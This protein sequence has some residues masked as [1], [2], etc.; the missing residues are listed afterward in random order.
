MIRPPPRSTLFPYTTLFRSV[1]ALVP[2][3]NTHLDAN[4]HS[5]VIRGAGQTRLIE[6]P[7][8]L[9]FSAT[10]I[11]FADGFHQG[12]NGVSRPLPDVGGDGFGG[13]IMSLGGPVALTNCTIRNCVVR[14][15]DA[16]QGTS[17][18]GLPA[19]GGRALGAAL[20]TRG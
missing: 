18:S 10:G 12:A 16:A 19:A 8:N 9:T 2:K 3:F 4:G 1:N 6:V 20:Y 11:T 7:T 17:G 14:G 15:G 5:I 13:G